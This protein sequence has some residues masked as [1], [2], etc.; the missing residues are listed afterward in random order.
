M[1]KRNV[2]TDS[3]GSNCEHAEG[4][5][6]PLK[7]DGHAPWEEIEKGRFMPRRVRGSNQGRALG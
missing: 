2:T 7:H 1:S 5:H 3:N 6:I 4:A